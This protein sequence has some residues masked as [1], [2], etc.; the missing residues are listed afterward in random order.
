LE[1]DFPLGVRRWRKQRGEL[2]KGVQEQPGEEA[3]D[4]LE[5]TGVQQEEVSFQMEV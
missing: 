1:R 5:A 4:Q 3:M 2:E